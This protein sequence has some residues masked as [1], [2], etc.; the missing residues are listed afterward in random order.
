MCQY[1]LDVKGLQSITFE[2]FLRKLLCLLENTYAFFFKTICTAAAD[3]KSDLKFKANYMQ[4]LLRCICVQRL[5]Y[6]YS[7]DTYRNVF[8]RKKRADIHIIQVQIE[9][10]IIVFA[11]IFNKRFFNFKSTTSGTKQGRYR[12]LS[13][14]FQ[15][16]VTVK[17]FE[18]ELLAHSS[19]HLL[20]WIIK[21]SL[22]MINWMT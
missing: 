19:I 16:N 6:Q 5:V 10:Y 14:S 21:Q 20:Y 17:H 22:L 2:K 12:F 7:V 18:Y 15:I 4:K 13:T 1:I 9:R 11:D 3:T 8:P